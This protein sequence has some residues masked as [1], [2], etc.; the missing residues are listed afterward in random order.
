MVYMYYGIYQKKKINVLK[1]EKKKKNRIIH[2]SQGATFTRIVIKYF[3][4]SHSEDFCN[5]H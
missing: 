2:V 3:I 1:I 4:N 5:Y